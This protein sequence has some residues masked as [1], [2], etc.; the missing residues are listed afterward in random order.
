MAQPVQ[1]A[2]RLF[3]VAGIDVH[4]HWTWFLFAAYE[5]SVRKNSYSTPVW[6]V[7][8][9][10][11]LFGIVLLH[12]FGHAFACRSVGGLANQI[13]LWPLGG[14]AYVNPPP[15][16]G[17]LL[18]SIAAGPLVNVALLPITYGLRELA[19]GAGLD[20]DVQS[21]CRYLYGVNLVLLVFNLLPIYP[22]DGGKILQSLLWF[23]MSR[24]QSLLIASILGL[25][26]GL[27]LVL[28]GLAIAVN[29]N[30]Y[31]PLILSV[32]IASR[33]WAGIQQARV[34]GQLDRLPRH[35]GLACPFCGA[36]PPRALTAKCPLCATPFDVFEHQGVCPNCH[37]RV[38][39]ADCVHCLRRHPLEGWYPAAESAEG[40][41]RPL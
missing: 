17:A 31:W 21:Y 37:A 4:L 19:A 36:A 34:L 14:V 16:P 40:G 3:R 22:L 10:L 11:S 8:E 32:F 33:S 7:F 35:A 15:R 27:V 20:P 25:V 13:L 1:G 6:T 12:E 24:A 41:R 29:Q 28:L 2:F 39:E 5:I 30:E 18:W 38:T 9:F 26:F 23:V